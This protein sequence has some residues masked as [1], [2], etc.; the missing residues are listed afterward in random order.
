M[1][2]ALQLMLDSTWVLLAMRTGGGTVS[3]IIYGVHR[4]E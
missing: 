2:K 4:A 1:K 3:S